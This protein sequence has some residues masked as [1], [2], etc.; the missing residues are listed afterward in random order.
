VNG[1]ASPKAIIFD[2]GRVLIH[3]DI[4]RAMQ[5]LADHADLS[6][7]EIW[8]R[9]L[10]HP[11]WQDWQE[12]RLSPIDWHRELSAHLGHKLEFEDFR[13]AWNTCLTPE[14]ILPDA[15]LAELSR[16]HTLALLSNTDPFHVAHVEANFSFVRYFPHRVYSCSVGVTKPDP[17]IY[18]EALRLC[19]VSAGQAL[20]IDDVAEN[21]EQARKLGSRGIVFRTPDQLRSDLVLHGITI[22]P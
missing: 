18:K 8:S 7:D 5:G 12:G 22:H 13:A 14:P 16:R 19:G 10:H 17:L 9:I 4:S 11:R 2:I 21:V 15:F 20:F 1:P 3:L 6:P